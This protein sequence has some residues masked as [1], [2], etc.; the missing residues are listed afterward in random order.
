MSNIKEFLNTE[1]KEHFKEIL[2]LKFSKVK[3][4][5]L[6]PEAAFKE[7][8][9]LITIICKGTSKELDLTIGE[10]DIFR[11]YFDTRDEGK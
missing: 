8:Q 7:I 5:D 1:I 4:G 3:N 6:S 11:E 2:N 10:S 9:D